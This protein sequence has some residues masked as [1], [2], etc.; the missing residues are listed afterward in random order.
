MTFLIAVTVGW[1][2]FQQRSLN[3][4][5]NKSNGPYWHAGILFIAIFAAVISNQSTHVLGLAAAG[6][7]NMR[8]SAVVNISICTLV[9]VILEF[10]PAAGLGG[11]L[12]G[13]LLFPNSEHTRHR[14]RRILAFLSIGIGSSIGFLFGRITL[15]TMGPLPTTA[16]AVLLL[17]VVQ[18]LISKYF[19]K[20]RALSLLVIAASGITL[21]GLG[22]GVGAYYLYGQQ[23]FQLESDECAFFKLSKQGDVR[24][25][26]DGRDWSLELDG[27]NA[28]GI[29]PRY[30]GEAGMAYLGA[31]LRPKARRTVVLGVASGVACEVSASFSHTAIICVEEN[32]VLVDAA[33]TLS[34]LN[35]AR[36]RLKTTSVAYATQ[37]EVSKGS[38]A[39]FDLVLENHADMRSREGRKAFTVQ[40]CK[41]LKS[42][43]ATNGI[44]AY[45]VDLGS[46]S[47]VGVRL[48][49]R[50]LLASFPY[51]GLARMSDF[52]A[53]FL[54]SNESLINS[55]SDIASAQN[56]LQSNFLIVS[57]LNATF[58][59]TNV[60]EFVLTHLLIG[61]RGMRALGKGDYETSLVRR[62]GE[63]ACTSIPNSVGEE[64]N[65]KLINYIIAG[66][67][68]FPELQENFVHSGCRSG[69][70]KS[71]HEIETYLM[72]KTQSGVA[73]KLN[74]WGLGLA[75]KNPQLLADRLL[76]SACNDSEDL[77]KMQDQVVRLPISIGNWVGVEL[78]KRG[79][80]KQAQAMFEKLGDVCPRSATLMYNCGVCYEA[81]GQEAKARECFSQAAF[82]DPVDDR[83]HVF[84]GTTQ[85]RVAKTIAGD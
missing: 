66:A 34:G 32:P 4:H 59:T 55:S 82:L 39:R 68:E 46:I 20:S 31:F 42:L 81:I 43:L 51:C 2:L 53:I 73:F 65:R 30:L 79:E 61:E 1:L 50:T 83:L 70:A 28:G 67:V 12:S 3:L 24:V 27:I 74:D 22:K 64:S 11:A 29:G 19:S 75:Q 58:N 80:Y 13:S 15:I 38:T 41:C 54:A 8:G 25:L 71:C 21:A 78:W 40:Y 44:L 36:G 84:S 57:A 5:V 35:G 18:W 49:A 17:I 76:W 45:R 6:I 23:R 56:I 48:V 69:D 52:E 33:N 62:D 77:A 26:R 72:D 9:S 63:Q 37:A 85:Q 7:A 10:I 60:A 14:R 16:I 47:P